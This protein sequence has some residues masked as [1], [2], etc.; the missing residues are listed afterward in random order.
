MFPSRCPMDYW[1]SHALKMQSLYSKRRICIWNCEVFF[2]YSVFSCYVWLIDVMVLWQK[3]KVLSV[4]SKF[5]LI[6]NLSCYSC[7][8]AVLDKAAEYI[9]LT[10]PKS[11]LGQ[12]TGDWSSDLHETHQCGFN[13]SQLPLSFKLYSAQCWHIASP[14]STQLGCFSICYSS[15]AIHCRQQ[16]VLKTLALS[17]AKTVGDLTALMSATIKKDI[18]RGQAE[19]YTIPKQCSACK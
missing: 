14:L 18:F 7:L 2:S 5:E 15:K 19:Y 13:T 12:T 3:C 16:C 6:L 10:P 8:Q 4:V 11:S 9:S 17:T 1:G